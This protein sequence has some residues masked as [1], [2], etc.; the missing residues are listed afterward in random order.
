[1]NNFVC[2][3]VKIHAKVFLSVCL[4]FLPI[5]PSYLFLFSKLYSCF[6]I[7]IFGVYIIIFNT[8]KP[9]GKM[10]LVLRFLS[11]L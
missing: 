3:E 1:M 9:E 11:T 7:Q 4:S 6:D 2:Q 5:S 10:S 8:N